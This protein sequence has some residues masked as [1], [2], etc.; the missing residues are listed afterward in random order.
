MIKE[1]V[2]YAQECGLRQE[3]IGAITSRG[4][5][6]VYYAF[7]YL[8]NITVLRDVVQRKYQHQQEAARL[9]RHRHYCPVAAMKGLEEAKKETAHA[10]AVLAE[11][12]KKLIGLVMQCA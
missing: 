2:E 1:F 10:I 7:P 4:Q 6:M 9:L 12:R 8:H 5:A 3:Q 11:E